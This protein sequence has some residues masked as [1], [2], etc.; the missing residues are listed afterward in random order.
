VTLTPPQLEVAERE[1][2]RKR[3]TSDQLLFLKGLESLQKIADKA[4]DHLE[5]FASGCVHPLIMRDTENKGNTGN[6]DDGSDTYWTDH[7]CGV[8][9]KRWT[10]NQS[11]DMVGGKQGHPDDEAA[12]EEK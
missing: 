11:W 3:L 2:R 10:T 12:Q 8:C 4:Q 9:H 6:W 1:Y 7:T 5:E